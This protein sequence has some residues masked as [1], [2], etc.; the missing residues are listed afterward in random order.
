[1]AL[2]R[3]S[4]KLVA[5]AIILTASA[6]TLAAYATYNRMP[7]VFLVLYLLALAAGGVLAVLG[8]KEEAKSES[9]RSKLAVK[10]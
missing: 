2:T 9:R 1:M 7:F 5:S 10:I 8:Q 3:N 4:K 6:F